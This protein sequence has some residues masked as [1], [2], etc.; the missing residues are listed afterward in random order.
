MK[1]YAGLFI[2]VVCMIFFFIPT[3]TITA[4]SLKG[5]SFAP[6]WQVQ[7]HSGTSLFF[8]DVKQ[9]KFWPVF[10]N[11]NEW[12][13]GAGFIV[14]RQFSPVFNLGGQTLYG[15]LSGTRRSA[16]QYF[17]NDYIEFTLNANMNL[18]NLIWKYDPTRH[19][20]V[21]LLAGFGLT[22]YNTTVYNLASGAVIA[23]VGNGYGSSFG[24]RTLE[25]ILTGGLGLSYKLNSRLNFH[26]ET[27]NHI[28]NSDMMDH[29]VNGFK[30]DVYNYTSVGISYKFG[31][32]RRAFPGRMVVPATPKPKTTER[33]P[34]HFKKEN[35]ITPVEKPVPVEM[36][37]IQ[38]PVKPQQK[39]VEQPKP[40]KTITV[41]P[42]KPETEKTVVTKKLSTPVRPRLEYRVQ[43]R[44]SYK[45]PMSVD[46][47]TRKYHIIH[48]GIRED[49][50]RGYY[51]YTIG[52]YDTYEQARAARDTLRRV[53]G[54]KDAFIVAF[55]NGYRLDKLP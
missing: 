45:K 28:M 3:S 26:F 48:S 37:P 8:G 50:H 10:K 18:T 54:I 4:Q 7:I 41:N 2:T 38:P 47:L 19:Y 23:Q 35:I 27:T 52:A 25:G 55:K 44:A 24:G 30:Y 40:K 46:Y 42:V 14:S 39:T 22:N 32:G 49:M 53:N 6:Y 17:E 29:W 31:R 5:G 51:I 11:Q 9:N 20:N 15:Q 1:K 13:M 16:N 12:R 34:E 33:Q 36:H 43:I 21:Y